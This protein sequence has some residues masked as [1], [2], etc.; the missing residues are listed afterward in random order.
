MAN[1]KR[2][3]KVDTVRILRPHREEGW[4][5]LSEY[6]IPVDLLEK[7]G[8]LVDKT[9]PDIWSVFENHFIDKARKIFQI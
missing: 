8:K 1:P 3:E 2:S 6:E 9:N 7:E 4:F 5:C